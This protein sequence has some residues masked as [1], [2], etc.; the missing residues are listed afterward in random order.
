MFACARRVGRGGLAGASIGVRSAGGM[1]RGFVVIV[2]RACADPPCA[3][4]C[5]TD[6]LTPREGG[7]VRLRA[8]LCIGCGNCVQACPLGAVFWD[9]GQNKPQICVYCGYCAD[10]CP[11]DVL[12]LEEVGDAAG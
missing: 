9:P 10:Y 2:C 7:G 4:V 3:R 8:N 12:R 1:R 6:A 5:P 11:Y